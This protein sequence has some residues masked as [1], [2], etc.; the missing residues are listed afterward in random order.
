VSGASSGAAQVD[1]PAATIS[2]A[3][4]APTVTATATIAPPAATITLVAHAPTVTAGATIAAERGTISLA[5]HAPVATGSDGS[6]TVN[7]EVAL[8]VIAAIVPTVTGAGV[9]PES[10]GGHWSAEPRRYPRRG[11]GSDVD[12]DDEDD[13]AILTLLALT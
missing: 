8:I 6:A 3:A 9:L 7:A 1:P 4:H 13:A 2:L 11:L 12:L 5:A 10:G